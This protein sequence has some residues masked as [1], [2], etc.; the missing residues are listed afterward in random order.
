MS[1]ELPNHESSSVENDLMQNA[2]MR[3]YNNTQSQ[4]Q[5]TPRSLPAKKC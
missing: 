1:K 5:K 3:M 4:P 2:N